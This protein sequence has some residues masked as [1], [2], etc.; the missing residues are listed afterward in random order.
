MIGLGA[1][2][3]RAALEA[4]ATQQA[5]GAPATDLVVELVWPSR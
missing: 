1:A 2:D 5:Y 3:L 4:P